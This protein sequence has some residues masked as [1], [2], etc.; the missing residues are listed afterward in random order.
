M[1]SPAGPQGIGIGKTGDDDRDGSDDRAAGPTIR[2]TSQEPRLATPMNKET[3]YWI[4]GES[5]ARPRSPK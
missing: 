2:R 5:Q 4:V 1:P 3:R